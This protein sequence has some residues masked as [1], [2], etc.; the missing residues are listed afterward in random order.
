MFFDKKFTFEWRED[1]YSVYSPRNQDFGLVYDDA[2][3]A[4]FVYVETPFGLW[5]ARYLD[6]QS[7]CHFAPTNISGKSW[8]EWS[9]LPNDVVK[10]IDELP[11]TIIVYGTPFQ[12]SVWKALVDIPFGTTTT[13]TG[14]AERIH[15]PGAVRAV[16]SAIGANRIGAFIPCH[17]VLAKNGGLGGFRWGLPLKR[18]LLAYEAENVHSIKD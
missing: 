11:E 2:L 18:A 5:R 10:P 16:G 8:Q 13:Y 1:P 17:R 12:I 6:D 14:I 3:P 4:S 15:N 9:L 7:I